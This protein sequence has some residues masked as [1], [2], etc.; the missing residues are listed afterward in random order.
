[1]CL[2]RVTLQCLD[3]IPKLC[4]CKTQV[5]FVHLSS[6]FFFSFFFFYMIEHPLK[7]FAISATCP[8]LF[9]NFC[10]HPNCINMSHVSWCPPKPAK[11]NAVFPLQS[12]P[13]LKKKKG[14]KKGKKRKKFFF[15]FLNN[16]SGIMFCFF[17]EY[18]SKIILSN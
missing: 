15:F 11:C 9:R 18:D 3:Y 13:L 10:L 12:W 2:P 7:S 4:C 5:S 1:M 16:V 8:S 17:F 14:K 6:L